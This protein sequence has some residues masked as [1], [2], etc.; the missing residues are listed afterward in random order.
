MRSSSKRVVKF[1]PPLDTLTGDSSTNDWSS[2]GFSDSSID[3]GVDILG[4]FGEGETESP[5]NRFLALLNARPVREGGSL[6]EVACELIGSGNPELLVATKAV[7]WKF[8]IPQGASL[9]EMGFRLGVFVGEKG[10]EE[11]PMLLRVARD[12]GMRVGD[13]AMLTGRRGG[14]L[15]GSADFRPSFGAICSLDSFLYSLYFSATHVLT[16]Q[17]HR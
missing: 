6:S 10:F 2:S 11:A 8:G 1:F 15:G 4:F 13:S 7:L 12:L 3:R 16:H 5:R 14:V 9:G 17:P